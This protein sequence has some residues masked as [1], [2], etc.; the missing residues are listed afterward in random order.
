M[1]ARVQHIEPLSTQAVAIL[2]ELQPVTGR[3][4]FA[5]PS[6]RSRYHAMSENAITGALR[7]MGYTGL[8]MTGHGFRSMASTLLNERVGIA[9][10]SSGS[11]RTG[12][13][14]PCGRPTITPNT[15]SSGGA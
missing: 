5:F 4:P 9:M 12:S 13:A 1:K 10:P 6:V 7:R 2:R 8:D 14:T 11:W 15:C 3:F